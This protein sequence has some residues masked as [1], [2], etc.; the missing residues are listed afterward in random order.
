MGVAYASVS[1]GILLNNN[2]A[3]EKMM[4]GDDN[5]AVHHALGAGVSSVC[6]LSV[7]STGDVAAD[8]PGCV[9][10]VGLL[11]AVVCVCAGGVPAQRLLHAV[12]AAAGFVKT[13]ST[14]LALLKPE[15]DD[16]VRVQ[17]GV[18]A[19]VSAGVL[20]GAGLKR[21]VEAMH[22]A[23]VKKEGRRALLCVVRLLVELAGLQLERNEVEGVICF[24]LLLV[25]GQHVVQFHDT[26][27]L[28]WK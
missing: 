14:R 5:G 8:L 2:W 28:C 6:M 7:D 9:P 21:R 18:L 22:S 27:T 17:S 16:R 3:E 15:L 12:P 24:G 13:V 4:K 23:V 25:D 19:G 20:T 1:L 11:S 10:A 26:K